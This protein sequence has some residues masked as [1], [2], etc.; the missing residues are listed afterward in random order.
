MLA[1]MI[2]ILLIRMLLYWRFGESNFIT[3]MA[4]VLW[5][6]VIKL[7]TEEYLSRIFSTIR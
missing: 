6:I 1:F 5:A 2:N 3:T 7:A 4:P